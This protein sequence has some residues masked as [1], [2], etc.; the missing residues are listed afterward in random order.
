[1][2]GSAYS[3]VIEV[4]GTAGKHFFFGIKSST[5]PDDG[6]E[7]KKLVNLTGDWQTVA[8]PLSAFTGVNLKSVY[9]PGEFVF[10]CG[11]H[12]HLRNDGRRGST[13]RRVPAEQGSPGRLRQCS[14][15]RFDA[16]GRHGLRHVARRPSAV[17]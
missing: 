6:S 5:Q 17:Q 15:A 14:D 2:D 8:F 7:V 10:D 9:I 16:D 1:M 3:Y 4:K 13:E 11:L 12:L